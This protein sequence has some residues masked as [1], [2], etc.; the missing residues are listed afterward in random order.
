MA[1]QQQTKL[2][3]MTRSARRRPLISFF[4]KVDYF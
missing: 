2:R 1:Y 4:S 3:A